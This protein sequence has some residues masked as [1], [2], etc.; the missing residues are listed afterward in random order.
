MRSVGMRRCILE[1]MHF[2]GIRLHTGGMRRTMPEEMEI[3]WMRCA[4]LG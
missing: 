1:Q 3:G 2:A 4:T